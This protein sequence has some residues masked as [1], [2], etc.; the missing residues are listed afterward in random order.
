[1]I[2]S[3]QRCCLLLIGVFFSKGESETYLCTSDKA[4]FFGNK[5]YDWNKC[6]TCDELCEAFIFLVENIHVQFESV[7]YSGH[8]MFS[9]HS[10]F[11]GGEGLL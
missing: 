3:K 7:V 6:L 9:I 11:F 8:K 10:D 5:K 2:F 4:G 1:M